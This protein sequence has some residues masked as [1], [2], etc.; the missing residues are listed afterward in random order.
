MCY[1]ALHACDRDEALVNT[2]F[3]CFEAIRPNKNIAAHTTAVEQYIVS[4]E[5]DDII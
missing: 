2:I 3:A 1:Y 5:D 4:I